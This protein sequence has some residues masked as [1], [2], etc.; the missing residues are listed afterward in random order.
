MPLTLAGMTLLFAPIIPSMWSRRT[1]NSHP[2]WSL[3]SRR[4]RP[5][6]ALAVAAA[7]KAVVVAVVDVAAAATAAMVRPLLRP[8]VVRV[9][10]LQHSRRP[11]LP[12]PANR[13][14]ST[15]DTEFVLFPLQQQ[16]TRSAEAHFLRLRP[17]KST[18]AFRSWSDSSYR[19]L[20]ST[21]IPTPKWPT[22]PSATMS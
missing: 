5:R 12:A 3:L 17:T 7:P 19:L 8:T 20:S 21:P 1:R 2:A 18:R 11:F 14:V 13:R 9:P 10:R 6:A 16:Q 22:P 4:R 15:R